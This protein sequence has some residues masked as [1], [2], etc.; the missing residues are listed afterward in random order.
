MELGKAMH[1]KP[2]ALKGGKGR[3]EEGRGEAASEAER[4]EAEL[5]FH[6]QTD[7]GLGTCCVRRWPERTWPEHGSA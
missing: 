1:Q 3:A 7:W 4:D 2:G 6:D 5:A